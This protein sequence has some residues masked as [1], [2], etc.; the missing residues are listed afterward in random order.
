M[1][2]KKTKEE[3]KRIKFQYYDGG[4]NL[5]QIAFGDKSAYTQL[6]IVPE[7]LNLLTSMYLGVTGYTPA[8]MKDFDIKKV[9][10]GFEAM[11]AFIPSEDDPE[12][13]RFHGNLR[14]A[15]WHRSEEMAKKR[16]TINKKELPLE[17]YI[18]T[19]GNK[20]RIAGHGWWKDGVRSLES[21][22]RITMNKSETSEFRY[23]LLE[24]TVSNNHMEFFSQ[25]E[26]EGWNHVETVIRK[27]HFLELVKQWR[28][29]WNKLRMM[30]SA[31]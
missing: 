20:S 22:W 28:K 21:D 17:L 9:W 30:K 19:V 23:W 31:R 3:P 7:D 8:Y 6:A 24:A 15:M 16:A 4:H 2:K 5:L 10:D 29:Q 13:C 11:R 25:D 1:P 27:M 18:S 26:V 14:Y 12:L